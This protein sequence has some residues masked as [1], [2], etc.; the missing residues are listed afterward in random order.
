M[1]FWVWN[2]PLVTFARISFVFRRHCQSPSHW[3]DDSG[4]QWNVGNR[5]CASRS[6]AGYLTIQRV[7]AEQRGRGIVTVWVTASFNAEWDCQHLSI[8]LPYLCHM[9][10][11]LFSPICWG[12]ISIG[13]IWVTDF[14]RRVL[15]L[16]VILP[17]LVFTVG[18]ST[19]RLRTDWN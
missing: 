6:T 3:F 4:I 13:G 5:T 9:H 19:C 2:V 8:L 11:Q 14:S 1:I 12:A 15:L 18:V 16:S 10:Q 17:S 7:H